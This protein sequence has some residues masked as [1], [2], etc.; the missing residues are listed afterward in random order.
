MWEEAIYLLNSAI[1]AAGVLENRTITARLAYDAYGNLLGS[2]VGVLNPPPTKILFTG[3]VFDPNL[4]LHYLRSRFYDPKTGRFEQMDG[5]VG[6]LSDPQT[7][8]K[9]IYTEE[10]PVNMTDPSGF[11]PQIK[12]SIYRLIKAFG[13]EQALRILIGIRVTYVLGDAYRNE[14]NRV[15]VDVNLQIGR[16]GDADITTFLQVFKLR[17]DIVDHSLKDVYEIKPDNDWSIAIG[18]TAMTAYIAAL[19]LRF[20]RRTYKPGGWN[21]MNNPYTVTGIPGLQFVIPFLTIE[22]RNAGMGIIAYTIIPDPHW[23]VALQ[24]IYELAKLGIQ[25][26][27]ERLEQEAATAT[28]PSLAGGFAI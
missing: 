21:P 15:D 14:V 11:A 4:I 7:L 25:A 26:Y 28:L 9:F 23:I 12:P 3:Q 13:A 8:Q 1:K 22:A 2:A 27:N 5:F 17:P 18:K 6:D 20:P 24:A 16:L 10:D 19:K